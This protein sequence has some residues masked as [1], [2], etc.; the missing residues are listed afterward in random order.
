MF[1]IT[2]VTTLQRRN[3]HNVASYSVRY[4]K[5]VAVTTL[6]IQK[7]TIHL[8]FF[9]TAWLILND[10]TLGL[11]AGTFLSENR[12]ILA[13]ITNQYIKVGAH[14]RRSDCD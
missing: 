4:T 9:N 10:I 2:Q 5:L 13:E 12:V 1:F 6:E 11:A 14:H 8:S 7:L 3:T